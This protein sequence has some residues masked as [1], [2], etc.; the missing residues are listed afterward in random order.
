MKKVKVNS[1]FSKGAKTLDRLNLK[2]ISGG[3]YHETSFP[4]GGNSTGVCGKIC[5]IYAY[6]CYH[7]EC[8]TC[9]PMGFGLGSA[10]N[11]GQP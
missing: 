7:S 3:N 8:N 6:D 4:D 5:D 11:C 10:G 2:V 1:L 9:I